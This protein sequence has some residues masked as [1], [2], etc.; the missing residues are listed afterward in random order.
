MENRGVGPRTRT[1]QGILTALRVILRE[2]YSD[3]FGENDVT[4]IA[5]AQQLLGWWTNRFNQH[6]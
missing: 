3:L 1:P 5:I 4:A 2:P 6:G